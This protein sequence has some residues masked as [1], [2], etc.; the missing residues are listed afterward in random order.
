MPWK[1][2][3][4]GFG[5]LW[6]LTLAWFAGRRGGPQT[7]RAQ[8]APASTANVALPTHTAA[9][10]RRALDSGTLDE[11]ADVL[12]GMSTPPLPDLD[13]LV[14]ALDSPVQRQAIEQL[15]RV[16]W[17]GGDGV[18]ARAALR[19]AFASGPTWRLVH[20]PVAEKLPPLYPR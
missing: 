1:W 18:A 9:D 4:L 8:A 16:R 3:A 10:L 17:A 20:R 13:A 15:R 14:A 19:E 11:V 12:R 6:L 5:A 2:L 7:A